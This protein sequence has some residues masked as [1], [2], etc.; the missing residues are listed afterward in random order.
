MSKNLIIIL[1]SLILI[2]LGWW[3]FTQYQHSK[4]GQLMAE[5]ARM[6]AIEKSKLA[7]QEAETLMARTDS[8]TLV[9]KA[10]QKSGSN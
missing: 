7:E 2:I 4:M 6:E 8:L 3:A 1:Q 9:L 5:V 10:C